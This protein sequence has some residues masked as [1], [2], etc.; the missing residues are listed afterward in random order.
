MPAAI[1][2]RQKLIAVDAKMIGSAPAIV[3]ITASGARYQLRHQFADLAAAERVADK[4]AA[5]RSID[6]ALWD[7]VGVEPG[8]RLTSKARVESAHAE[9]AR[10]ARIAA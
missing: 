3:A 8:T 4:I 10:D 7:I 1:I 2:V 5:R 9:A 6:I